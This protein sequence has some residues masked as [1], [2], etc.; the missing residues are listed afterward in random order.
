MT[1]YKIDPSHSDVTF[2]IKHLMIS[3]VTGTFKTF[4][5]TLEVEDND[6]TRAKVNFEAD[7]DSVDTKSEQR[8]GHLKSE[9]FFDAAKFPKM[10]F[11]SDSIE[12]KAGDEYKIHGQLTIKGVAKP[13]TL[14]V[15]FNGDVVDPWGMERKGFEIT[16]KINRKDFGLTWSAVTEAGGL[17]VSDDVKLMM[18]I[19]VVKQP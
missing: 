7:I 6:L 14:D 13:V 10:T 8:D 17:V 18:N 1:T 4:D 9:D 15:D 11:V 2:K 5:G 16:G 19:E 3:S 12:K